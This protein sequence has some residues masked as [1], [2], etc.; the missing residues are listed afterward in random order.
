MWDAS[1]GF[2]PYSYKS[3]VDCGDNGT[4]PLPLPDD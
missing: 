3:H 2:G 1:D 4:A